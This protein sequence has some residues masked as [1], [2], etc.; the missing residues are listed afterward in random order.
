MFRKIQLRHALTAAAFAATATGAIA[1]TAEPAFAIGPA[2]VTKS[3]TVL[4]LTA[5]PGTQDTIRIH[6]DLTTFS[7]RDLS[8]LR[9]GAG[10]G[11]TGTGRG[12][13]DVICSKTGISRLVI[14]A[15]DFDDTIGI[16]APAGSTVTY[17][18]FGGAGNDGFALNTPHSIEHG[19]AGNDVLANTSS[20]F[21]ATLDGGTGSD[22]CA[23][24][25]TRDVLVG[26][27]IIP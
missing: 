7:M 14:N 18:A 9:A 4:T 13:S 25:T 8:G 17:E 26:C 22:R 12:T 23:R 19:N 15:G 10:S 6:E 27:E 2:T 11:C 16:G 21:P 24:G 3:G 1:L 20:Q 5:S